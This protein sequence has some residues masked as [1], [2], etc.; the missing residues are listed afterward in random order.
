MQKLIKSPLFYVNIVLLIAFFLLITSINVNQTNLPSF[1]KKAIAAVQAI[2]GEGGVGYL[3]AFTATNQIGNS[4]IYDDG[5]NIGIGTIT[6]AMKLTVNGGILSNKN[7]YGQSPLNPNVVV[8]IGEYQSAKTDWPGKTIY[9][10]GW[11]STGGQI[12]VNIPNGSTFGIYGDTG[13][14][15]LEVTGTIKTQSGNISIGERYTAPA[16]AVISDGTNMGIKTNGSFYVLDSTT[17]AF[18]NVQ[19]NDYWV[20]SI[21]KWASQLK[22]GGEFVNSWDGANY[23]ACASGGANPLT[24]SCSCP[25][26]YTAYGGVGVKCGVASANEW[27]VP[28][29]CY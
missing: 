25:A 14:A 5:T 17:N 8:G 9:G 28:K 21:G 23:N 26:G 16:P 2:T 13:S 22:W 10:I 12:G 19:A 27:C 3:S 29:F 1:L 18:K 6:P 24:G 7:V 4:I 15:K 11:N 20:N